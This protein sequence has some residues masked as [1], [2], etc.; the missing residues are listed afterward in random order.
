M[1]RDENNIWETNPTNKEVVNTTQEKSRSNSLDIDFRRILSTWPFILL[2]GLLGYAVGSIYLRYASTIY[3]VSTSISI[4]EKE[5]VSLGQAFFGNP[6]DPFNDR[7]A[8]FKS[9]SLAAQLVDSLG[10][11]FNAE[12]QGRFRNKNFYNIIKWKIYTN[13]GEQTPEYY[14]KIKGFILFLEKLKVMHFGVFHF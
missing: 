11:Q 7:I 4:E 10:L 3:S 2:F 6:R 12:A 1:I 13:P 5:E 14:Q 8:Y 9:P